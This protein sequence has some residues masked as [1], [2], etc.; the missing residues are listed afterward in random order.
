MNEYLARLNPNERRFVVA[1]AVI[2]FLVINIFWVWPHFAD[3]SQLQ[4]R[5]S[6]AQTKLGNY[7]RV[8]AKKPTLERD[9]RELT[10]EGADVPAEDQA[11]QFLRTIQNE[12]MR[13]RVGVISTSRSSTT[14]NQFFL[15]QAQTITVVAGE[16]ELVDFLYSIG[17]GNSLIRV[18]DLSVRPDPAR[19]Q[20]NASITLVASYQKSPTRG[21]AGTPAGAPA[22]TPS[23]APRGT[24]AG[25][26]AG[27]APGTAP[28]APIR[29]PPARPIPGP[30]RPSTAPK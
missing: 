25:A 4:S 16:K 7:D 18:K 27:S 21:A 22:A 5:R 3:W 8:I 28:A 2:F 29:Q 12:A 30:T 10:R 19:H 15:E 11:I 17:S 14:T 20:L 23:G 24:P 9:I 1:V 13:S 6:D 26:R